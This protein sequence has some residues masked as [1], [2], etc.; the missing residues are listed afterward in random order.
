MLPV[1]CGEKL[2]RAWRT[3]KEPDPLKTARIKSLIVNS[4]ECFGFAPLF[5]PIYSGAGT[6][7]IF[8]RVMPPEG[9]NRV[10]NVE[11]ETS[12][13]LLEACIRYFLDLDYRII[14]MEELGDDLEKGTTAGKFV[15][16]TFD[17]GYSDTFHNAFPIFRKYDVP[18]TVYITT[19]FPDRSAV[20]WWYLLEDLVA[21]N[22]RLNV[23]ID[24]R[25]KQLE[26][27]T[28]QQKQITF[29]K[30]KLHIME[31]NEENYLARLKGIFDPY[32]IDLYR[33]TDEIALTWDQVR[34]MGAY[35]RI[36]LGA[37]SI[38]HLQ[39]NRISVRALESEISGSKQR[40]ESVLGRSVDH[41]A[42][43]FGNFIHVGRREREMVKQSHFRTAVS[44]Q[45]GNVFPAH[46]KAMEFLPRFS[47]SLVRNNPRRLKVITSGVLA[48]VTN[49]LRRMPVNE[50]EEL[51]P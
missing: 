19:G 2:N 30:L 32:G 28:A 24:G 46:S 47:I 26:C 45:I 27:S 10:A 31:S 41:F 18:F 29:D 36:T 25:E 7:L 16:F 44:N 34:I 42:Y 9:K 11:W 33:K 43:P 23:E 35:P 8:H 21:A 51:W 17:D 12:P 1:S 40:L 13:E 4:I 37:H 3:K 15:I 14:S 39:L 50:G 6:I 49:R 38:R 22:S 20:I 5:E 48:A